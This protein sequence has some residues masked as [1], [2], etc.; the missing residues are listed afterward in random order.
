ML[1]FV[2]SSVDGD[3]HAA[4][5]WGGKREKNEQFFNSYILPDYFSSKNNY[6]SKNGN[7]HKHKEDLIFWW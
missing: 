5:W 3:V 4:D 7:R 6:V 1:N 2:S